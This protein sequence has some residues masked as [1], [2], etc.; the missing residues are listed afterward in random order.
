[1]SRVVV[2]SNS[3]I[4]LSALE[5]SLLDHFD[6]V[7]ATTD[8]AELGGVQPVSDCVLVV[9]AADPEA[10]V[11]L[12]VGLGDRIAAGRTVILLRG[13]VALADLRP[14]ISC[15]GAVLPSDC[16]V[17]EV[18]LAARLVR[19]GL[20]LMPSQMLTAMLGRTLRERHDQA[21]PSAL[22]D[23]E[24]TVLAQIALGAANKIIARELDISDSTVRVHVRAILK[25]LGLQN[26]TQAAL[27]ASNALHPANRP[28]PCAIRRG[29]VGP[30]AEA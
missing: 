9:D 23:R 1:M 6:V 27:Y 15:L 11:A 16:S 18:T 25:K 22:T 5:K 12:L 14:V 28:E 13:D 10:T 26:R 4:L 8:P 3:R 30:A 17:D 19:Q 21:P 29:K 2:A 7:D 24:R 20:L